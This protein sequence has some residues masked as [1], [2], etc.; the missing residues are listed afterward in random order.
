MVSHKSLCNVSNT[1][2]LSEDE[3]LCSQV[4]TQKMIYNVYI[5]LA[6][7]A[8]TYLELHPYLLA[9]LKHIRGKQT[10]LI[11]RGVA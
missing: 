1:V 2:E 7:N 9:D 8:E 10:E 4:T 5:S 11:A 3:S 6:R